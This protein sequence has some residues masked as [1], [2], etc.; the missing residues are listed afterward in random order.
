[1]ANYRTGE[2]LVQ[3]VLFRA[4]EPTSGSDFQAAALRYL[5]RAQQAILGG[6]SEFDPEINEVWW[7]L[8]GQ[9]SNFLN[10]EPYIETTITTTQGSQSVTFGSA[11]TPVLLS[12][13]T[14]WFLQIDDDPTIH[15]VTANSGTSGTL[16]SAYPYTAV[17]GGNCKLFLTDYDLHSSV[18]S[19]NGPMRVFEGNKGVVEEIPLST[20]DR[21]WRREKLWTGVPEFFCQIGRGLRR[22][23]FNR[24]P[25]T[26]IVRV[27]YD[28]GIYPDD[29]ENDSVEPAVPL[30]FRKT[31]AD[32]ALYFLFMDKNDDRAG[33]ALQL[34]VSGIRA[35]ARDNRN[36]WART[37]IP[38][39]IRP[40]LSQAQHKYRL[41]T[42]GRLF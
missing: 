14:D 2:D 5:N 34:A 33:Q 22:V 21:E 38:M 31:L 25:S 7:W 12:D 37:G 42:S 17:S 1:M 39:L 35:M 32:A 27:E 30:E 23:R 10:L 29:I 36:R 19:L 24:V 16:D 9:S 20:M 4:G 18:I 6:G 26:D 8:Q 41:T 3:D 15:L 13:V 28:H 11:P 40:R